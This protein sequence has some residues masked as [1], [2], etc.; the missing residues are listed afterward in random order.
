MLISVIIPTCARPDRLVRCLSCVQTQEFPTDDYE[1]IVTDD[2]PDDTSHKILTRDFP[3]VRWIQ[4][5][6][7]GP[8]ANRNHGATKASGDWLIFLDDDCEPQPGWL[9]AGHDNIPQNP[10]PDKLETPGMTSLP[11]VLEGKTVCPSK[12][13]HP[14]EE[15]VENLTG[16]NFWSCN[17]AVHRKIFEELGGFD[18]DFLE[19]GGEDM[20]FAWRIK[21]IGL[22]TRF[23]SQMLVFHPPRRIGW[24]GLW[25]RTWMIRWMALY[26]LKTG[27]Q[28]ALVPDLILDLLRSTLHLVTRFDP[29]RWRARCF[30]QAWKWITFPVVLPY[31]IYWNF[32]FKKRSFM[33]FMIFMV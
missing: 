14:L 27:M 15:Q 32:R 16:D 24:K 12:T 5:P 29:T 17:L 7:R 26:R 21:Q 20:E 18:E 10:T 4:G 33:S 23:C 6:R 22:S 25:H 1:I 11:E 19:A 30:Q 3:R 31:M 8:A 13:D 2:S 9:E 28:S